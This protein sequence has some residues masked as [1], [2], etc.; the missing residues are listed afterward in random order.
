[1]VIVNTV[2]IVKA[3]FGLGESEVAWA[4]AASE[5][6]RWLRPSRCLACSTRLLIDLS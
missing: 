6:G 1:M 5:A 3:R 2:V 4:L